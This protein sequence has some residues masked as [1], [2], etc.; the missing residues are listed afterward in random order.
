MTSSSREGSTSLVWNTHL[1][2]I[3]Y[4]DGQRAMEAQRLV[5]FLDD[6]ALPGEP[7]FG[8]GDLNSKAG[9]DAVRVLEE[10]GYQLDGARIDWLATRKPGDK[11]LCP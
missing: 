7:I 6:V 1:T 3:D 11:P 10:H 5:D 9:L 8:G 2:N 4:Q